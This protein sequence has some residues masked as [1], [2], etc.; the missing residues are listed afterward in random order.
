V[1]FAQ[2]AASISP[3]AVSIF[4]KAVSIHCVNVAAR[5]WHGFL[6]T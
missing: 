3:K 4:Q 5:L 6:K 2:K 1:L